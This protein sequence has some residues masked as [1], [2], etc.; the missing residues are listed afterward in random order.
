MTIRFVC[1]VF[2][3]FLV[4]VLLFIFVVFKL[5]LC[6]VVKLLIFVLKRFVCLPKYSYISSIVI[7]R[8][9]N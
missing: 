7:K 4:F 2:V 1:V 3:T 8:T 5:T 9:E 6:Y